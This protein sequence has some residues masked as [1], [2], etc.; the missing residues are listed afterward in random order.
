MP[1]HAQRRSLQEGRWHFQHGPIDLVLQCDGQPAACAQAIDTA[2]HRFTQVLPALVSELNWLRQPVSALHNHVFQDPVAR[3]MHHAARAA[4]VAAPDGFVTPMAA[5]A[6]AVAQEMV[7]CLSLAG[8][9]RAY[10]NNGGDIAVY[11][12]DNMQ[13]RVGVVTDLS[14]ALQRLATQTLSDPDTVVVDGALVLDAAMPVRGVATSGWQGRSFSLGIA[15]SVTVLAQTAAQA[16]VA[17][18]LIANAVNLDDPRIQRRPA[19]SLRDDTDLGA[20]LVTVDVPPLGDSVVKP[21]LQ[22]GLDCARG[23]QALGLIHAA[24]VCCQGHVL[25]AE[26]LECWAQ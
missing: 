10:V 17:A 1:M 22:L 20:R 2:W 24:Y 8:V 21:A 16:D 6:G 14:N 25:V 18:T 12:Q 9:D 11:L 19:N 23:M 4:A 13:W 26:P 3:R 7:A 15:D 5:V